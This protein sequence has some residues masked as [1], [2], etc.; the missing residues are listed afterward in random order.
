MTATKV[1]FN[2][3]QVVATPGAL[4]AL[5]KSDQLPSEFLNRHVKGD[6]GDVC[7][8][9]GELNN[10]AIANEGNEEKQSRVM[11]VY[12]TAQKDVIWIITEW[13]RSATTILLPSEY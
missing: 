9:D 1:K 7:E 6:W 4:E 3:G 8:S 10:Q 13:D 12:K 2:L 11:S 5:N